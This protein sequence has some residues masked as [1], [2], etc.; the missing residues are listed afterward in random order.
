MTKTLYAAKLN[1]NLSKYLAFTN[2]KNTPATAS[3]DILDYAIFFETEDRAASA[4][5]AYL[6]SPVC[7]MSIENRKFISVVGYEFSYDFNK[8]PMTT[9]YHMV[10]T[11]VLK[12]SNN[13]T[14]IPVYIEYGDFSGTGFISFNAYKKL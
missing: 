14:F 5:E 7:K 2:T 6:N 1:K 11:T 8:F 3:Q 12:D 9:N 4:V 13:Y 10:D